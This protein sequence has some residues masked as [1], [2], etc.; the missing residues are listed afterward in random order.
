MESKNTAKCM[1]TKIILDFPSLESSTRLY[2]IQYTD[3]C[4]VMTEDLDVMKVPRL[5]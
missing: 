1:S 3:F 5:R 4:G 2:I